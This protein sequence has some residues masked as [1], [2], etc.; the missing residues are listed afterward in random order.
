MI[1]RS[2]S[3]SQNSYI[4]LKTEVKHKIAQSYY[5]KTLPFNNVGKRHNDNAKTN[6]YKV[7]NRKNTQSLRKEKKVQKITGRDK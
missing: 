4:L 1:F 3:F 6:R 5:K 2:L 7:K